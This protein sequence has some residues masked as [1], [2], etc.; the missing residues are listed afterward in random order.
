MTELP[1][2]KLSDFLPTKR[3]KNVLGRHIN[4]IWTVAASPYVNQ[5][6][7]GVTAQLSEK[8]FQQY[9]QAEFDHFIVLS[10]GWNALEA[11]WL[12]RELQS[13][14]KHSDVQELGFPDKYKFVDRNEPHRASLGGASCADKEYLVYM[15]WWDA[16]ED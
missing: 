2:L 12:E 8:R 13:Y 6:V 5:Y 7:V 14:C 15:A 11:L 3:H 10:N 4:T 1:R 16:D 9:R